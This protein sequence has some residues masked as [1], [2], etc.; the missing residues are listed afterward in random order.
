MVLRTNASLLGE[1]VMVLASAGKEANARA[2]LRLSPSTP[3]G[4]VVTAR[5]YNLAGELVLEAVNDMAPDRLEFNMGARRVAE[6]VY[7]VI[8][9]AKAPWGTVER[10]TLK[11]AVA[12]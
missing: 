12:R 9:Q 6:G 2:V 7:L 8:V 5:L 10:R 4:T 1:A 3:S 11:M